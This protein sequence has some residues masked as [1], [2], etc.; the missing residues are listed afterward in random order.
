METIKHRPFA[1]A[2]FLFVLSMTILFRSNPLLKIALLFL[3]LLTVFFLFSNRKKHN[4]ILTY[5]IPPIVLACLLSFCSFD[6]Y[7]KN[8]QNYA[9]N[10]YDCKFV[11]CDESA[12]E[13][14]SLYTV[15]VKK[16]NGRKVSF[17][18]NIYYDGK[19]DSPLFKEYSA[20]LEFY[21]QKNMSEDIW[22]FS[23][24]VFLGASLDTEPTEHRLTKPFPSYWFNKINETFSSL[25]DKNLTGEENFL[26]QAL[27]LGNK[28]KLSN[29]T[30]SNFRALGMS[31]MLA[32]SGMHL[33]ILI[34]SIGKLLERKTKMGK[35][36]RYLLVIGLT[37]AYAGITGFSPSVKRA[38]FM[39]I[40]C[41]ASFFVSRRADA[42]TSLCSAFAFICILSPFSIYDVGLWLSFLATYGILQVGAPLTKQIMALQDEDCGIF[43]KSA[44]KLC[45]ALLFG[46]V[47]IMFSLPVMWL[48]FGE[49]AI[50]SPVMN[51]I[52]T[53]PLYLLMCIS[54]FT[55]LFANIPYLSK[56]LAYL[57]EFIAHIMLVTADFLADYSPVININYDFSYV[58]IIFLVLSIAFLIIRNTQNKF[59]YFVP[60]V[61]SIAFFGVFSSIYSARTADD[62]KMIYSQT[63]YGESFLLVSENKG[64][65]CDVSGMSYPNAMEAIQQMKDNHISHLDGYVVTSYSKKGIQTLENLTA[66]TKVETLY[67]P[68]P[69]NSDEKIIKNAI[70]Q[71][72]SDNNIILKVYTPNQ[73]K[74]VHFRG[75]DISIYSLYK[76][77]TNSP[78]AV[79]ISFKGDEKA[80]NYI[81]NTQLALYSKPNIIARW[82]SFEDRL[83]FGNYGQQTDVGTLPL[84]YQKSKKL[85]F[86]NESLFSLYSKTIPKNSEI[87]ILNEHFV[88]SFK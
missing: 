68:S 66:L 63:F 25:A 55:M 75:I 70:M 53:L 6:I 73:E 50:L 10:K 88:F 54:P 78:S 65:F 3:C 79:C 13:N 26:I 11:V 23:D 21:K 41:Y 49:V 84:L 5:L 61:L 9:D 36:S 58:I 30:V 45:S 14:Y 20:K 12:G 44:I 19:L 1:F 7:Y 52:F 34:G 72:A 85:F 32:V 33:S 4:F 8:V 86:A 15:D 35:K 39:L 81:G 83:I 56:L 74:C 27:I 47:P 64:L 2:C 38:A 77:K 82:F 42:I 76:P 29:K 31:H 43:K 22:N 69:V 57:S 51:V 67:V 71:Y 62:Q 18:A 46:V 59:V 17:K 80:Y 16:V 87:T 60:L 28:D 40:L 48:F 37:F 24:G